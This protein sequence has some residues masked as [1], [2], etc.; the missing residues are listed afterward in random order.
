MVPIMPWSPGLCVDNPCVPCAASLAIITTY[1]VE[2]L[3]TEEAD[4]E[5]KEPRDTRGRGWLFNGRPIRRVVVAWRR[6]SH[7]VLLLLPGHTLQQHKN[8]TKIKMTMIK[9][10][11]IKTNR[12]PLSKPEQ[13]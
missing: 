11:N 8:R 13:Q 7:I 4:T 3:G 1:L 6:G 10:T 5:P 12:K 9:L 2:N